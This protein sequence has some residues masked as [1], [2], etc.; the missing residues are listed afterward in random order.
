MIYVGDGSSI[1]DLYG[2]AVYTPLIG[3]EGARDVYLAD[4][5]Y[6]RLQLALISQ[7]TFGDVMR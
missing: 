2:T 5:E 7:P 3:E 1:V 6:L 4:D